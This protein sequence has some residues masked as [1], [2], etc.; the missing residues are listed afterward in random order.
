MR[1]SWSIGLCATLL[2]GAAGAAE[3]PDEGWRTY[4][5]AKFGYELSYPADMDYTAYVEGASGELKDTR[6]R[7]RLVEFEVWPPDECPR[8]PAD[9]T[10]K[11][12]GIARAK[13]MTQADGPNGASACGDPVT[14]RTYAARHGATIYE[15]ELTC[16]RE[17]Y[18]DGHDDT[19]DAAPDAVPPETQAVLT[20][21]GTKGPTYFVDIS[22][23]WRQRILVADPVGVD[24]RMRVTTGT[25]DLAVLRTILG[26]VKTFGIP[27]PPGVCIE[28]HQHR[29]LSLGNPSR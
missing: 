22:P 24:P 7:H 2:A 28:D 21:E 11:A 15:L 3:T 26:T 20:P 25:I 18:P 6:T 12:V 23:P 27:R 29:S 1:R 19:D 16:G 10:A 17:T 4:R 5:N 13:T 14:V 8:Q 9:A